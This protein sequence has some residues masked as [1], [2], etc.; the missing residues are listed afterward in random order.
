MKK[1]EKK[2]QIKEQK[3]NDWINIKYTKEEA[4]IFKKSYEEKIQQLS[5]ERQETED[6]DKARAIQNQ[7]QEI[8]A[9]YQNFISINNYYE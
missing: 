8:E 4:D 3:Q 5:D 7:L 6:T 1:Y 2:Y 9:E